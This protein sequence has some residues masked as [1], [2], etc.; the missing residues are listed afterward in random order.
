MP[1]YFFI[2]VHAAS[3][4]GTPGIFGRFPVAGIGGPAT[5]FIRRCVPRSTPF[6]NC[7]LWN[8]IKSAYSH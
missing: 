8:R 2:E 1:T 6:Q 5:G 4:L 7:R 3:R